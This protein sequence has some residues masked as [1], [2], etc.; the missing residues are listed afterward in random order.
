M[1]TVCVEDQAQRT[2][3]EVCGTGSVGD[4]DRQELSAN[5][6]VIGELSFE[7][8]GSSSWEDGL[9]MTSVEDD[10]SERD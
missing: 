7:L 3:S 8:D 9:S 4:G 1:L 10:G 2:T 6:K 5:L